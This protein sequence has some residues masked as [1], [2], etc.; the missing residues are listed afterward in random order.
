MCE[1]A[2]ALGEELQEERR[3]VDRLREESV[4]E[5]SATE[6]VAAE[7]VQAERL[8]HDQ[9]PCLDELP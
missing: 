1:V 3:I 4:I 5:R 7:L 8:A 6:K 2:S 9:L